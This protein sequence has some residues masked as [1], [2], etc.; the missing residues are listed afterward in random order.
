M[1]AL[2]TRLKLGGLLAPMPSSAGVSTEAG[3]LCEHV[4]ETRRHFFESVVLRTLA[5][6]ALAELD[7]ARREA[8][9]E[10]WDGYGGRPL[11]ARAYRQ[12][13]RFLT[14][15]PTTTPIPAISSDPDGEVEVSWNCGP[16]WVFSVSI[17]PNGRL[18][19]AGLFG[20]S[21]V[22]GTEW[23]GAETPRP[24]LEGVGRLFAAR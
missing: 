11:D 14:Q 3:V 8:R 7:G 2:A 15:L 16:R 9:S 23:M 10:N 12:A 17:G 4:S 22:Y 6:E 1:T 19:Y 21:K 20:T 13:V 5:E 24:V 18:T